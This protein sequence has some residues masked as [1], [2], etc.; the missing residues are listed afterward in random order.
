M[1]A[2]DKPP[3]PK[4][5]KGK[6]VSFAHDVKPSSVASTPQP[7]P[8]PEADKDPAKDAPPPPPPSGVIGRLEIHQSG[9]VKMRLENG[10][11]LDVSRRCQIINAS[12]AN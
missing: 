4:L 8:G 10:I 1:Q 12:S 5:D 9:A 2:D 3:E 6:K 7:T 11:L